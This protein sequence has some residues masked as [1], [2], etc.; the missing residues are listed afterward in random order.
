MAR[1]GSDGKMGYYPTPNTTLRHIAE[2]IGVAVHKKVHYLDPCC[3]EGFAMSHLKEASGRR[4]T[5]W[6][7]ELDEGRAEEARMLGIKVGQGSIFDARINPLG[8]MGLLYLNPPYSSEDGERTEMKFLYHSIKWLAPSG[9]LVFIVPEH[10]FE[11]QTSRE[12]IGQHFESIRVFRIA[13]D[14]YPLFKQAVLFGYKRKTRV[15]DG[16]LIIPPPYSY[17]DESPR[18]VYFPPET[19]VPTVFQIG[20]SISDK[21]I[22]AHEPLVKEKMSGIYKISEDVKKISPLL[23]LKRGHLVALLSSGVLNGEINR[24]DEHIIVKGFSD[25][26]VIKTET[27]K[28]IIE[29]NTYSV[30]IRVIDVKEGQWYDVN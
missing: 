17:I 13:S 6:G 14:E 29:K 15:E 11:K 22:E 1:L 26:V 30:G 12:W 4:A 18:E 8:S 20:D 16:E 10:I 19:E 28:E 5:P 7:I 21:E 2:R 3:G 24:G 23:P 25:R 27:D 9:V